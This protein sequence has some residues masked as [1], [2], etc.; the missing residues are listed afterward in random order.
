MNQRG[1]TLVELMIAMLL[2][3]I[4]LVGLAASF[5]LAMYGVTGG[6]LQTVATNL[7]LEVIEE[8]KRMDYTALQTWTGPSCTGSWP[9][10]SCVPPGF[11]RTVTVADYTPAGDPQCSGSSANPSKRCVTATVTFT[12]Q[13]GETVQTTV[14]TVIAAP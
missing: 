10:R 7:A 14:A 8:A 4:A 5:P 3:A 13:N 1:I 2:L 6:G 12:G 11:T 9:T